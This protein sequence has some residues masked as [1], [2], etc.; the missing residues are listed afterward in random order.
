MEEKK[1]RATSG[2]RTHN[3]LL[4]RRVHCHCAIAELQI[5]GSRNEF[6]SNMWESLTPKQV[7]PLYN[8]F[9]QS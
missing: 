9:I 6:L 3:F 8:E 4:L 5:I 2:I 1:E 7:R